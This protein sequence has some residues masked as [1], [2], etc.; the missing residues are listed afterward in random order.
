MIAAITVRVSGRAKLQ[1]AGG[2]RNDEA[3]ADALSSGAAR[4]VVGTAA[5]EQPE[6]AGRLVERH[7]ADRIAVALDIR[8]GLAIGRGWVPGTPGTPVLDALD[9]LD[10]AG[11]RTFVVTAI[12][13]DGLLDGPDL[14]LLGRAIAATSGQV[15]ASGGVSSIADLEACRDHGAIGAIVGRAIYTGAID[16][17]AAIE[18]LSQEP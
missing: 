17:P 10:R 5:L 12:A 15:I 13:R 9:R 7:G 16:L 2:L 14:E 18:R 4:V 6:F 3:V 11:V 8:D 1:V